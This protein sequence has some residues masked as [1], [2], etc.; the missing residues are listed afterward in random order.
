MCLQVATNDIFWDQSQENGMLWEEVIWV[1]SGIGM[2]WDNNLPLFVLDV[3]K[4]KM[5]FSKLLVHKKPLIRNKELNLRCNWIVIVVI[6][7]ESL[8]YKMAANMVA[9]TQTFAYLSL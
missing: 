9:K 3:L 6:I 7:L 4:V 5:Y 8:L 2:S 1:Q